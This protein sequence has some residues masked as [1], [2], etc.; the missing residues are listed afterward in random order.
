MSTHA[1]HVVTVLIC[2]VGGPYKKRKRRR[3]RKRKKFTWFPL[4]FPVKKEKKQKKK[5]TRL[6][7]R[8][9]AQLTRFPKFLLTSAEMAVQ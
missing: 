9:R 2:L 4:F 1:R 3:K 7:S 8:F 6:P 5:F